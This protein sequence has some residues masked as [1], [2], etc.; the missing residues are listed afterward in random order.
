VKDDLLFALREDFREAG[1]LRSNFRNSARSI[2]ISRLRA[3][4]WG[5]P[6]VRF[7]K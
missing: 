1:P 2:E 3:S 7:L 5:F 6:G 4:G